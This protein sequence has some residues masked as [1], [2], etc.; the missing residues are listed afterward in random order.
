MQ[1][2]QWKM[3]IPESHQVFY[4]VLVRIGC[5]HS[6]AGQTVLDGLRDGICLLLL[7]TTTLKAPVLIGTCGCQPYETGVYKH[8]SA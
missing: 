2:V 3:A 1:R 7:K 5:R 8:P 6:I 4:L